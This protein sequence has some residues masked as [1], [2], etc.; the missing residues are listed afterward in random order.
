M[1]IEG[2]AESI[3]TA[4]G[5]LQAYIERENFKGYDPI[6]IFNS[7][8]PFRFLPTFFKAV[9]SQLQ[10]RSPLNLR[11]LLGIKK[12]H[13]PMALG[14][15]L[16]AYSL[17]YRADRRR[18]TLATMHSLFEL[19]TAARSA[20]FAGYCWGNNFAWAGRGGVVPENYPNLVTTCK[21]AD[22]IFEFFR[23]TGDEKALAALRGVQD[24]ILKE[25]PRMETAYGV[26]FSYTALKKEACHNANM[27]AAEIL[28]K[29]YSLSQDADALKAAEAAV[30]FTMFH[31]HGDGHWN[32]SIDLAT[33][34]ERRQIDFHQGYILCSLAAF[35]LYSGKRDAYR[36][37]LARGIDF[38]REKQFLP[39]GR[40]KWRFPKIFPI[41]THHQAIGI[42]TFSEMSFLGKGHLDFAAK[43]ADYTLNTLMS[44]DGYFYF[45]VYKWHKIKIPY[46]RWTQSYMLLALVALQE[47]LKSGATKG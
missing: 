28:A 9:M 17:Q 30:A 37:Q 23:E 25:I 44:K 18:E 29:I 7:F 4:L 40:A 20:G 41:E 33:G 35:Q 3:S 45:R 15:L 32:Y 26:C 1:M 2:R 12:G 22:G 47:K 13:N 46:M 6:D 19:L 11:P 39:N 10:L 42:I 24:F 5:K 34:N 43:I 8:L 31:Q 36:E 14:V 38:Y 27:L 21:A 16:K